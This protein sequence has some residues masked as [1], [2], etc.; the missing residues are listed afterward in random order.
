MLGFINVLAFS[1]LSHIL[2]DAAGAIPADV[3]LAI[4]VFFWIVAMES[5]MWFKRIRARNGCR[6][7]QELSQRYE[8]SPVLVLQ[9]QHE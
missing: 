6:L 1:P 7:I 4:S 8:L 3:I 5:W 2:G 9:V